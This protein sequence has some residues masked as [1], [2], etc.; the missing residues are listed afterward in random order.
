[1]NRQTFF[2]NCALLAAGAIALDQLD[3]LEKLQPRRLWNGMDMSYGLQQ[4]KA[5][6]AG[7]MLPARTH[8]P[9]L[10]YEAPDGWTHIRNTATDSWVEDSLYHGRDVEAI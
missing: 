7:M 1:M 3:V 5:G 4:W 9:R 10:M 8:A 2:R 6:G